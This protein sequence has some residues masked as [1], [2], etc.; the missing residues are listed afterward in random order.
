[1]PLILATAKALGGPFL[2]KEPWSSNIAIQFQRWHFVALFAWCVGHL[3]PDHVL[4]LKIAD[5]GPEK[6]AYKSIKCQVDVTNACFSPF[7]RF[8]IWDRHWKEI[9]VELIIFFHVRTVLSFDHPLLWPQNHP[10]FNYYSNWTVFMVY[11]S[12]Y[13]TW[14]CKHENAYLE[15]KFPAPSIASLLHKMSS[16]R[17]V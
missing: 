5:T 13:A 11:T 3:I 12:I 8:N 14:T 15:L 4:W 6:F 17:D 2:W 10:F 1:M 16:A 9:F 7:E